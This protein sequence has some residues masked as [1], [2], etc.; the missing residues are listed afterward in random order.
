[1]VE[2]SGSRKT[3][4]RVD[5]DKAA[6]FCCRTFFEGQQSCGSENGKI[7]SAIILL[8]KWK[9]VKS[10][11]LFQALFCVIWVALFDV[12]RPLYSSTNS[13]RLLTSWSSDQGVFDGPGLS[14]GC[15]GVDN[16]ATTTNSS[17]GLWLLRGDLGLSSKGRSGKRHCR[18]DEVLGQV[19]SHPSSLQRRWDAGKVLVRLQHQLRLWECHPLQAGGF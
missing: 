10:L 1:M 4:E 6:V 12:V 18:Q 8:T 17:V 19:N 16:E 5:N 11:E 9:D 13:D 7:L 15:E 2:K 14:R 3:Q